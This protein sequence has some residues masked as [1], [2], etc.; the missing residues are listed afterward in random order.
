MPSKWEGFGL[1]AVEAMAAALPVICSRTDGLID[2]IDHE[3]N[4]LLVTP[5]DLNEL[6]LAVKFLI[7]NPAK[8]SRLARAAQQKAFQTYSRNT[9]IDNYARFYHKLL[10]PKKLS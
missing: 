10:A 6:I 5:N 1:S 3:Q 8:R 9:M 2:V 4:G 7:N